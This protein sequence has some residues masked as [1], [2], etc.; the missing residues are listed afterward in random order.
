M[1]TDV[2][3]IQYWTDDTDGSDVPLLSTLQTLTAFANTVPPQLTDF[4]F[5][6]LSV[7]V[8]V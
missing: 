2:S 7:K 5:V 8:Y 1:A 6:G 4:A 3:Q